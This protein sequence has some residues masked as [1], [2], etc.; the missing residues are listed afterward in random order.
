M[1]V[2]SS[3]NGRSQ[4]WFTLQDEPVHDATGESWPSSRPARGRGLVRLVEPSAQPLRSSSEAPP[5]LAGLNG[6]RFTRVSPLER[7]NARAARLL[8]RVGASRLGPL[9]LSA[10]IV[11]LALAVI[12]LLASRGGPE[13]AVIQGYKTQI[14][15][16]TTE[17]DQA[18]SAA[19][20]AERANSAT[21]TQLERRRASALA[22]RRAQRG[23]PGSRHH[24]RAGGGR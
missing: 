12:G 15:R 17:R 9:T 20:Q 6:A 10:V 2:L 3:R 11:V 14:A 16:L 1:G 7:G 5:A 21:Q 19:A 13:P 8:S 22:E 4:G 23:E 18:M 24:R